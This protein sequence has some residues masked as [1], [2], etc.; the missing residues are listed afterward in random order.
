VTEGT[1]VETLVDNYNDAVK[2]ACDKTLWTQ[3]GLRHTA[4]H[5]S[6]PWWT[7]ELTV[8]RKRTNAQRKLYQRTKN[9]E[10]IRNRRKMQYLESKST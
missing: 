9:N 8:L 3:R 1:N 5:K 4:S 7:E 6:V 2:S 10:E